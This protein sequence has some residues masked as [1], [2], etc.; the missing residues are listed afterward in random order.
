MAHGFRV[1]KIVVP[2]VLAS[3]QEGR[4]LAVHVVKDSMMFV[5]IAMQCLTPLTA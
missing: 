4:A 2:D 3:E 1:R 5:V